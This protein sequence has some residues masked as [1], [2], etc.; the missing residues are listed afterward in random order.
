LHS[1]HSTALAQGKNQQPKESQNICELD[2]RSAQLMGK[3]M[4]FL[5]EVT[6]KLN[7]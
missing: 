6:I 3:K 5:S 1:P 2:A 4:L 7:M